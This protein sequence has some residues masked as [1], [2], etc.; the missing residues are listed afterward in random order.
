MIYRIGIRRAA[1]HRG[2]PLYGMKRE[3][4]NDGSDHIWVDASNPEFAKKAG[5]N[6]YK[7]NVGKH[8]WT[9]ENPITLC[10]VT[11]ANK[12]PAKVVRL[13]RYDVIYKTPSGR[14][15]TVFAVGKDRNDAIDYAN[16]YGIPA[17]HFPGSTITN[18]IQ[19]KEE[20]KD[21]DDE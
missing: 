14:F 11:K 10:K 15:I 13:R 6:W 18:V 16:T 21:S 3:G 9:S 12:I 5:L 4:L 8:D 7:K 19:V 1:I 20:R 2:T 17:R